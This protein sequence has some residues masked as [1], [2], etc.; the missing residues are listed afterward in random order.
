[1]DLL[2]DCFHYYLLLGMGCTDATLAPAEGGVA[3][4]GA[5]RAVDRRP[6]Q[7]EGKPPY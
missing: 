4:A 5:A 1:M 7:R 3:N 6:L 2:T